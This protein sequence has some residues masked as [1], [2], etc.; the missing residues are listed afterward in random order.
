MIE[1]QAKFFKALGNETR[2]KIVGFLMKNEHCAC[3]FVDMSKKDQTTISRHLKILLE[4]GI[5]KTKKN[6]RNSIYSIKD[7]DVRKRL[8]ALGIEYQEKCCDQLSDEGGR[9]KEIVR[10]KYG[11]IAIEGGPCG[12]GSGCCGSD[13]DPIKISESLGYSRAEL[14]SV[15]G[16]NLG[17]GCGNP[18][19]LGQIR[20]GETVLDL[21]S[22]A[23]M[24]AFLAAEKVGEEGKV[25]GIDLTEEMV[26]RARKNAE[27]NGFANVEFKI[28][29]IEDLP[30]RSGS[31]DVV[32]SNCVINLAP[33][34]LKVF[35]EA[36]R[37]L[38]PG[39]RMYISDMVLLEELTEEERQDE[40]LISG[41]VG[42]A[43][44]KDDYLNMIE[45]T[46]FRIDEVIEDEGIGTRQY[47]SLP[48]ESI[49]VTARKPE[50]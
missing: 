50:G 38:R 3:D 48:V 25:I 10:N 13:V 2:L 43:A 34:K 42:G 32:L 11:K 44:L 12:C 16:S 45:S 24:D 21:G 40:D 33:N 23:G 22:G 27:A 20:R 19:A 1:D 37:V 6:G 35:E 30:L 49:K 14:E 29:D 31:V 17:L 47:R 5:V 41:C 28:G 9:I 8:A 7:D 18:H 4:A 26:K 46:G 15:P 36:F 39:G